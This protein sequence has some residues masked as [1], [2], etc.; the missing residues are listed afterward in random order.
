MVFPSSSSW[1]NV[2]C[3]PQTCIMR[4]S[5]SLSLSWTNQL[6]SLSIVRASSWVSTRLV[7]SIQF[8]WNPHVCTIV[9]EVTH[10]NIIPTT[11]NLILNTWIPSWRRFRLLLSKVNEL[12]VLKSSLL[13]FTDLEKSKFVALY[14]LCKPIVI[15]KNIL[16]KCVI[17]L[18]KS[19]WAWRRNQ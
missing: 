10:P 14:I 3:N 15:G 19:M 6:A 1:F 5:L 16:Y 11:Y 8:V 13:H 9:R 7:E 17:S 2:A 4:I 12:K 18:M